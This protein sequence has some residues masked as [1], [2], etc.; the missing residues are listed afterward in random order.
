MTCSYETREV[1]GAGD[2]LANNPEVAGSNPVPATSPRYQV[3]R[4]PENSPGA[5]SCPMGADVVKAC[6]VNLP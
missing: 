1:T 2:W 4:P 6:D 3:N 5:V